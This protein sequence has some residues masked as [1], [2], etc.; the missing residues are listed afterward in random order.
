MKR[1][2]QRLSKREKSLVVLSLLMLLL[3]LGRTFLINPLIEHR[4]WVKSQ[5][6]IQPQLLEKSLRYITQKAQ[7]A[8]SLE[9]ARGAH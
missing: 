8:A 5:L 3:I 4:Q 7:I 6:D 1:L 9:K 2:W